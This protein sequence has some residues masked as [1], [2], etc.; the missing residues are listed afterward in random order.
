VEPGKP[1]RLDPA[2]SRDRVGRDRNAEMHIR[3]DPG[4]KYVKY[5]MIEWIV[6]M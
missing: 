2:L 4:E 3:V 5:I 6:P 1:I